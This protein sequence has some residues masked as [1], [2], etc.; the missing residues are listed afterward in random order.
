MLKNWEKIVKGTKCAQNLKVRVPNLFSSKIWGLK[1][2][3]RQS[4][5]TKTAFLTGHVAFSGNNLG[6]NCQGYLMCSKF[7][8]SGTKFVFVQNLGTKTAH[9]SK[10]R[11]QN[12]IFL[13]MLG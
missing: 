13:L 10:F 7:E 6:K 8:S 4:L 2:L 3:V 11:Y 5:G 12:C 1:P 9:A